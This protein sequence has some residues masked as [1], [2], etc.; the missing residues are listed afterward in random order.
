MFSSQDQQKIYVISGPSGVGKDTLMEELSKR[1]SDLHIAIT[2]TTR[3]PRSLELNAVNHYFYEVNEFKKLIRK[4]ELWHRGT[5]NS[6]LIGTG[7]CLPR[8]RFPR[9]GKVVIWA[10]FSRDYCRSSISR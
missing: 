7:R 10:R 3:P 1:N 8:N 4:N 5:R 2:A 9:S 6:E